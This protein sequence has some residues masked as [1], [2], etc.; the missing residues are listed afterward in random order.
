MAKF[1]TKLYFI[2]WPILMKFIESLNHL[3]VW[4]DD[5]K[6]KTVLTGILAIYGSTKTLKG[7][8]N[9]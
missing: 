5:F 6:A 8:G 2:I 4:N 3:E 9:P 7:M 1:K